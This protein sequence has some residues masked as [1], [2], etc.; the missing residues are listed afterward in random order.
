MAHTYTRFYAL[1][2]NYHANEDME[3]QLNAVDG[4]EQVTFIKERSRIAP[5]HYVCK[6]FVEKNVLAKSKEFKTHVHNSWFRFYNTEGTRDFSS[7]FKHVFIR[8]IK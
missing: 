6:D 5:I 4:Q 8:E 1:V 2:N 7:A 3:E